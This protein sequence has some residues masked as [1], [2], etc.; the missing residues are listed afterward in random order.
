MKVIGT[1]YR[2][3]N[4]DNHHGVGTEISCNFSRGLLYSLAVQ[5]Q[6]NVKLGYINNATN[7]GIILVNVLCGSQFPMSKVRKEMLLSD[8]DVE[9]SLKF[10]FWWCRVL[11]CLSDVQL[12]SKV[13]HL[14]KCIR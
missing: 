8:N 13:M 5:D 11:K 9:R 3:F 6:C 1:D 14:Y 10:V 7:G 2:K 12:E 4:K